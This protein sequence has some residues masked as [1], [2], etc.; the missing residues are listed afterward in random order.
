LAGRQHGFL[1]SQQLL[2]L[3]LTP[4]AIS[5]RLA[6]GRIH[7]LH[8]GVYSV[9][10]RALTVQGWRMAA[11]LRGGPGTVLSHRAAGSEWALRRWSGRA[12]ITVPTWRP[13]DDRIEIHSSTLPADERTVLD[14]IPITT[15]PRT[16]LDLATILDADALLRA[17][18][19]AEVRRLADP[20]SLPALLER[21]RGERGAAALRAALA[22]AGFG[23]G[24]TR[25]DLEELFARFIARHGLPQPELNAP[26]Q[27]GGRFYVADCMWRRQRLIVELQS[28]TY[29]GTAVAMTRDADRT[30][31]LMLADW[32]VLPVT[33]SQLRSPAT[34]VALTEDL[35]RL[36]TR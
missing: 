35:R 36:L 22:S 18:N 25:E 32:R 9:G 23:M 4:R 31:N 19:E 20:L 34:A 24:I 13:A 11:V 21:H 29:H 7:R 12:A 30:R 2:E 15:V 3:G 26:V 6:C 28:V 33:W 1:S 17:V 8:R 5:S 27:V 10:H 16:L 14:G